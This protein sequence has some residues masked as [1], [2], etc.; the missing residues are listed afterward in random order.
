[1]GDLHE[2]MVCRAWHIVG[3]LSIPACACLVTEA[4][5]GNDYHFT[6]TESSSAEANDSAKMLCNAGSYLAL[7]EAT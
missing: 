1:M 3:T 4:L 7:L 2:V 6:G 5:L